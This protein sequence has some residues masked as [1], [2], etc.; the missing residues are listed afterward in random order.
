M[1]FSDAPAYLVIFEEDVE[2]FTEGIDCDDELVGCL[3]LAVDVEAILQNDPLLR[4]DAV[5]PLLLRVVV[6]ESR[7]KRDKVVGVVDVVIVT[8]NVAFI[9]LATCV[10]VRR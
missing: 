2:A 3:L 1:A 9:E 7:R 4:A 8:E 10:V 5:T 6:L